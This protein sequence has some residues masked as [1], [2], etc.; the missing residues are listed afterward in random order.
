MI[1]F[2]G[3][4]ERDNIENMEHEWPIASHREAWSR[5]CSN[6]IRPCAGHPRLAVPKQANTR[7]AGTRPGHDTGATGAALD[8]FSPVVVPAGGLGRLLRKQGR[9]RSPRVMA[10]HDTGVTD[11]VILT[12]MRRRSAIPALQ[13]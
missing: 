4:Y 13:C 5:A 11:A 10:G 1:L 9:G 12:P 6:I 2:A 8:A 7:M 3:W